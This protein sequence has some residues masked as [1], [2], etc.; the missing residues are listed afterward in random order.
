VRVGILKPDHLGDMVLAAP[1]IAALR[2]RF[3]HLTLFC[4]PKNIRLAEHLFPGLRAFAMYLPHLDKEHGTDTSVRQRVELLRREVDFLICLRWD[5]QI[6]RLLTV[7]EIEFYTPAAEDPRSHVTVDQRALIS[8]FTGSYE[9]LD[10]YVYTHCPPVDKRPSQ[11]G[12]VGLC[13]SAGFPLNAWPLCHWLDLACLLHQRGTHIV[14]VGGP[15]EIGRLHVLEE[16]LAERLGYRPTTIV[17]RNDFATTLQQLHRLVDLVV[18]TDSGTAHLAA[19]VRPVVS[20]FG[21]SPWQKFAPLGRF[22]AILSRRYPCSPCR[23]FNRVE[24]NTCHTQECLTN[25]LPGQ[26]VSCLMAYLEGQDFARGALLNG[27]WMTAAPWSHTGLLA[28]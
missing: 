3:A 1:A 20:L 26:V 27:V 6:D 15:A 11:L 2:H 10:S 9:I 22:N 4:H 8:P 21:G 13:I 16:A 14:L 23:Q 28:A 5:G 17:G 7:P 18:A 24:A 25:L 12:S 19:L